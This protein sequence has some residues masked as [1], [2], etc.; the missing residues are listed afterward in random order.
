MVKERQ[1]QSSFSI[2]KEQRESLYA[3]YAKLQERK[4]EKSIEL[5]AKV[6]KTLKA[7]SDSTSTTVFVTFD[8]N[9]AKTVMDFIHNTGL[10]SKLRGLCS[11]EHKRFSFSQGGSELNLDIRRAP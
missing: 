3:R 11:D 6:R 2:P 1:S 4:V 7:E 10:L 8:T 9:N 5:Q